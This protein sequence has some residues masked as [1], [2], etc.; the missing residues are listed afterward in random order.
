MLK[1]EG[2]VSDQVSYGFQRCLLRSPNTSELTSLLAL[3]NESR[4]QLSADPESAAKLASDPLGPLPAELN[5]I[6]AAA[7]TLVGNVL[8]NLDEMVLKTASA[9]IRR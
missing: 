6:D 5:A 3:F 2:Q 7:M 8:L 9:P 4:N 1:H